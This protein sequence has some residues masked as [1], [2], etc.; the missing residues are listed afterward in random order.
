MEQKVLRILKLAM[1]LKR[2]KGYEINVDYSPHIDGLYVRAWK[3]LVRKSRSGQ[4]Y[5][6]YYTIYLDSQNAKKELDEII[7]KLETL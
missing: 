6:F 1:Q 5:E 3:G 2:D 4:E 7:L